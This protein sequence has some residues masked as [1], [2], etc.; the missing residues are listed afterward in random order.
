MV[1]SK[2]VKKLQ[3]PKAY[4]EAASDVYGDSSV[5]LMACS[6]GSMLPGDIVTFSYDGEFGSRRLLVVSTSRASRG[7]YLSSRGNRLLCVYE[8]SETI[9]SLSMV[10]LSFYKQRRL[11]YGRMNKTM[12][13]IFGITNFKTFNFSKI[14]NSF[15]LELG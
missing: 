5:K 1:F 8:L 3:L 13:K 7:N 12:D 2:F 14:A 6:P 9:P 4:K 11:N 10:F 15:K